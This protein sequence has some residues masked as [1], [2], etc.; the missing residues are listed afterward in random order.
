MTVTENGSP[1]VLVADDHS[2]EAR[3]AANA[4]FQIARNIKLTIRGL[5]V[6]DEG[7][8]LDTYAN[9]H[10]ELPDLSFTPNGN[11]REPTSRAELMSWFE[12]QG[13]V[14]LHWLETACAD[15]GVPLSTKLM[16]GGV[17]PWCFATLPRLNC[18]PLA[19]AA[20]ATQT[21]QNLWGIISVRLHTMCTCPCSLE[22]GKRLVCSVCYWRTMARHTPTEP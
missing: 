1:Y 12:T 11:V 10:S 8:A 21:I 18:W 22:E 16:A 6:I 14:A 15:A 13:R 17:S 20:V 5:Y 2:L 3:A 9:Y 7:L 19:V 4:A